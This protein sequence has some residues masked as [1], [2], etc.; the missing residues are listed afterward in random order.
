MIKKIFEL[1]FLLFT[2]L[3]FVAN[4]Y[5]PP[6]TSSSMEFFAF[7]ALIC[8]FLSVP[9]REHKIFISD[10]FIISFALIFCALICFYIGD[11][12]MNENLILFSLYIG[13]FCIFSNLLNFKN[14]DFLN[15]LL[16]CIIFAAFFNAYVV[17]LQYM[18]LSSD[19]LGIWIAD[20][21]VLHGRPYGNFGQPNLVSSLFLT[22]LCSAVLLFKKNLINI[23]VLYLVAIFIG[24]ALVPPS[25]KTAFLC[26]LILVCL[27][28]FLKDWKILKIFATTSVCVVAA[29]MLTSNTRVIDGSDVSTGR[30][31]IWYT[32]IDAILKSPWLGYGAL[33]TRVAHFES[34]ELDIV[35]HNSVIGSSHNIFL[36]FLVWFG[37]PLGI[38]V[39]VFF[40]KIIW[41]FVLANKNK[42]GNLYLVVPL[43]LHSQLEFPLYYANFLFLFAFLTSYEKEDVKYFNI[44]FI[45]VL[46][47]LVISI[48]FL[49]IVRDYNLISKN[50]NDLRFFNNKFLNA[51][52]PERIYP[53][54]LNLTGGQYNIFL[55][56]RIN[57]KEDFD[58][59]VKLTKAMPAFKNYVLI[60]DYLQRNNSS[61][62]DINYWLDK[63]RSSFS[64][65]EIKIL[66]NMIIKK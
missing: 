49:I 8:L 18:N 20:Y 21:D 35:P 45:Y 64:S 14:D 9:L 44:N 66:E 28:A 55:M 41:N 32:M 10:Q 43:L 3:S 27:S 25:S 52:Q 4:T 38:L 58:D 34:R 31:E 1:I 46:F 62:V 60:I 17:F 56:N 57:G 26:L 30:F 50:F 22:G 15:K 33:N 40:I 16:L 63:A 6:W 61:V 2:F 13:G 24:L 36:D 37:I 59:V 39:I 5:L 12:K 53:W 7:L 42:F 23:R 48:L 54:V 65:D 51:R 19:E 29:K 47:C 11:F